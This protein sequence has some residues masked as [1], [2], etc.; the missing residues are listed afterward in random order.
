MKLEFSQEIFFKNPQISN[1]MKVCA[2]GAKLFHA[3]R[4]NNRRTWQS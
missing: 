4:Q 1:F 3:Y 2:V